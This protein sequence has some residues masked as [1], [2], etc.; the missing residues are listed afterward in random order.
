M[1]K[2]LIVDDEADIVQRLRKI[3]TKEGFEVVTAS[4]GREALDVFKQEQ[5][6]LVITDIAM[7]EINGIDL[8]RRIKKLSPQT[9]VI[10]VTGH[11]DYDTA[12]QVLRENALDYIKK[13]LDL[14]NLLVALDRYLEK[15][16]ALK[17]EFSRPT[18]LLLD[19]DEDARN[20]MA[21]YLRKE[22]YDVL[23]GA[24]G[25]EGLNIFRE[26]RIDVV[27]T[28]IMM[29]KMG[30][31][32]LLE[33]INKT[34][35]D[36]AVILVT[37]VGNEEMVINAMREGADN[38]LRKPVDI[39]HLLVTVDK[40]YERVGLKRALARKSRDLELNQKIMAK[41]T[42]HGDIVIDLRDVNELHGQDIGRKLFDLAILP[43]VAVDENM[44]CI[45][46]NK[47]FYD[48][49]NKDLSD[50]KA[51]W[52]EVLPLVGIHGVSYDTFAEKALDLFNADANSVT[53][54]NLSRFSYIV[55]TKMIV[56]FRDR[57]LRLV[58][59]LFRGERK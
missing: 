35:G 38:F 36:T 18:V 40:A 51:R 39:E 6:G 30:G 2:V 44:H 42:G 4:D 31:L 29:P 55:F 59:V 1:E 58:S 19:D 32:E 37:G 34:P 11:G 57:E 7:P 10:I 25:E 53:V 17:K 52:D 9:E 41:L 24:D 13:P 50:I 49:F 22:G 46:A 26:Q 56:L 5:P 28:D 23:I 12:I 33:E 16:G 27:V 43:I 14:E 47:H 8:L 20:S 21:R 3:L 48:K 15:S 54:L 45:Y